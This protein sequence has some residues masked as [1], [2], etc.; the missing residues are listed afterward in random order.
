MEDFMVAAAVNT[1]SCKSGSS[2]AKSDR[3]LPK[4]IVADTIVHFAI[5]SDYGNL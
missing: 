3:R 2:I 4:P 1:R 5:V